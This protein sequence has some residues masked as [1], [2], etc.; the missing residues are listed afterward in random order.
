M[1]TAETIENHQPPNSGSYA[2]DMTKR[3]LPQLQSVPYLVSDTHRFDKTLIGSRKS[4]IFASFM[5]HNNI[6]MLAEIQEQF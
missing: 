2:K 3:A 4:S 1:V 6:G 5:K